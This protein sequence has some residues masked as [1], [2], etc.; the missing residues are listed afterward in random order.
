VKQNRR[1]RY[2]STQLHSPD[3]WQRHQKYTMEKRPSS[4]NIS[5]KTGYLHAKTET[6]SMSFHP[7]QLSTQSGL[8]TLI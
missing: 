2:E 1:P 7:V 5:G 8:R 3:F 4:T 6:R